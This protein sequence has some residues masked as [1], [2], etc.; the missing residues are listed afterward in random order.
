MVRTLDDT[1]GIVGTSFA[2]LAKVFGNAVFPAPN[3]NSLIDFKIMSVQRTT[4]NLN[5][6]TLSDTRYDQVPSHARE[7]LNVSGPL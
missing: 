6:S 5:P 2:N 1:G 7:S 4:D 3:P